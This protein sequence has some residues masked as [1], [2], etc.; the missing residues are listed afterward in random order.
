MNGI[1]MPLAI[2][3]SDSMGLGEAIKICLIGMLVVFV[4]LIL[5]D[6]IIA[7]IS[8]IVRAIDS[9]LNHS[10][11]DDSTAAA[12]TKTAAVSSGAAQGKPLPDTKS[13]GTLELVDTD[14]QTAAVI[15]A[16]VSNMS[17][18]PLNRLAFKSIKQIGED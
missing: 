8:R 5:M 11:K 7:I 13:A 4:L 18:I 10:G 3:Q 14:E 17:G 12:D 6:V 15:M 1:L 9:K 2:Y 16:I